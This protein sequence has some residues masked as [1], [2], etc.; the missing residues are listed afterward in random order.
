MFQ[1]SGYNEYGV[2]QFL[3]LSVPGFGLIEHLT[4]KIDWVLNTISM[5]GLLA[6]DHED[7]GDDSISHSNVELKNFS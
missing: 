3:N 7:S 1:L 5:V 6:L 2:D 4:D